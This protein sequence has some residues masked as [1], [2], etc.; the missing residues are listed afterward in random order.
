[1]RVPGSVGEATRYLGTMRVA[2]SK[3][4]RVVRE[5][6]SKVDVD[7]RWEGGAVALVSDSAGALLES[8]KYFRAKAD[9]RR[10]GISAQ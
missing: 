5:V 10:A 3:K 2:R 9:P 8:R 1:M 7:G 4:V 6:G